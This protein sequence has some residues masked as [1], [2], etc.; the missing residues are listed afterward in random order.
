M[1]QSNVADAGGFGQ[2]ADAVELDAEDFGQPIARNA[3]GVLQ[4]HKGFVH[5]HRQ[6]MLAGNGRDVIQRLAG[7]LKHHI[8]FFAGRHHLQRL[9]PGPAAVDVVK[10]DLTLAADVL[11]IAHPRNV[12]RNIAANLD[13]MGDIAALAIAIHHSAGFFQGLCPDRR[14]DRVRRPRSASHEVGNRQ[15]GRL[16]CD[17]P[18]GHIYWAFRIKMAGQRQVHRPLDVQQTARIQT[19]YERRHRLDSRA[20]ARAVGGH[21]GMPPRRAF[22]PAR[23]SRVGF[24]FHQRRVQNFKF[25]PPA[26]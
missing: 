9:L 14:C 25:Q 22:S 6:G 26:G 23:D 21:I 10:H 11:D 5:R 20:D 12:T 8:Q 15:A 3:S 16:T 7:L 17:V 4:R 19:H 1:G 18:A 13:R 24:D 2:T